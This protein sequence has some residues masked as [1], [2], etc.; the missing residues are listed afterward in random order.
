MDER[1]SDSSLESRRKDDRRSSKKH[2]YRNEN[3]HKK[4]SHRQESHIS[5]DDYRPKERKRHKKESKRGCRKEKK[6]RDGERSIGDSDPLRRNAQLADALFNVLELHPLMATDLPIMLVRLGGGASF[7]LTS[8]TDRSAATSLENLFEHLEAFGMHRDSFGAWIWKDSIVKFEKVEE[9]R[10]DKAIVKHQKSSSRQSKID[11]VLTSKAES[12]LGTSKDK[13]LQNDLIV[14]CKM[15]MNGENVALDG[16]P[17]KNLKESLESLLQQCGLEKAEIE[18]SDSEEN[19]ISEPIYGYGLPEDGTEE[20]LRQLNLIVYACTSFAA[21]AMNDRRPLKGPLL[22]PTDYEKL[23]Q[24]GKNK[25]GEQDSSDDEGPAPLGAQSKESAYSTEAILAEAKLRDVEM[26]QVKGI[27]VVRETDPSIREEWMLVPGKFDFL[28]SIKSGQA[29]KSRTFR[30][31]N[32]QAEMDSIMQAHSD[33]RG[34]SLVEQHRQRKAEVAADADDNKSWKWNRDNDLDSG[35]RVDKNALNMVLG[36]AAGFL[37]DNYQS[38]LSFKHSSLSFTSPRFAEFFLQVLKVF[39]QHL[40]DFVI[41]S[42]TITS[43]ELFQ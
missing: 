21:R 39:G 12:I 2:K 18:D 15:I 40:F 38:A 29:L 34:P 1:T 10:E 33:A 14:L 41:A 36:G 16:L 30:G 13:G 42:L 26:Q 32:I 19:E 23:D 43:H 4:K 8:M 24:M 3:R 28:S 9:R 22:N 27:A 25:E 31:E 6:R 11:K 20:A 17:D 7:D 5:S 37:E 35:R